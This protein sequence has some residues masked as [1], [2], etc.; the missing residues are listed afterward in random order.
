MPAAT[1]T[2]EEKVKPHETKIVGKG[3]GNIAK[4]NTDLSSMNGGREHQS[5]FTQAAALLHY[6]GV[7]KAAYGARCRFLCKD[8]SAAFLTYAQVDELMT[9]IVPG[10]RFA[11]QSTLRKRSCR[12][13]GLS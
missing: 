12:A 9:C 7:E 10:M 5:T 6:L 11:M 13:D 3:S 2:S 1:V 4:G 8:G